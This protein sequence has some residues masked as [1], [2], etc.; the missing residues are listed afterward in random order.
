MTAAVK[1]SSEIIYERLSEHITAER[2]GSECDEL[3]FE[4]VLFL[5]PEKTL[6]SGIVYVL[7]EDDLPEMPPVQTDILLLCTGSR[8][9]ENWEK[10][11]CTLF[12]TEDRT[13][14]T[15]IFNLVQEIFIYYSRWEES[16]RRIPEDDAD[17]RQ[18]LLLSAYIFE[19]PITV[20]NKNMEILGAAVLSEG[21]EPE[22]ELAKQNS[23]PLE[24]AKRL[25]D[26]QGCY[27]DVREPYLHQD[28]GFEPVYSINLFIEDEY[29]GAVSL[30][31]LNRTFRTG[32]FALFRY[33][34]GFI[35]KVVRSRAKSSS[36]S[37]QAIKEPLKDILNGMPAEETRIS[38]ALEN[39]PFACDAA[40]G[41]WLCLVIS[42][43]GEEHFLEPEYLAAALAGKVSHAISF[44]FDENIVFTVQLSSAD[45]LS[46]VLEKIEPV[47]KSTGFCIG[48]SSPFMKLR[49]IRTAYRKACCALALGVKIS[50][51]KWVFRYSDYALA[52]MLYNAKGEFDLHEILPAGILKLLEHDEYSRISYTD[53]LRCYLDNQM[54]AAGTAR[55]LYL[56]RSSLLQRTDKIFEIIETRLESAEER[57]YYSILLHLLKAGSDQN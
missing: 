18:M 29:K 15:R 5:E 51:G 50:S 24:A 56:H 4:S 39:L 46:S 20:T 35:E 38:S 1:L 45:D 16:L 55:E 31:E 54:N 47:L 52:S 13:E 30:S 44:P 40:D 43:C 6:H 49:D 53:T 48:V 3:I 32:D 12:L 23:I 8:R 57:L 19:N 26:L 17:I 10:C 41:C 36:M 37:Y 34:A 2:F 25:Q 7:H 27:L 14:L 42:S 9:P 33:L 11:R 22:W 28:K 21:P